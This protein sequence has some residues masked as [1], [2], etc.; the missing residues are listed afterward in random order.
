MLDEPETGEEGEALRALLGQDTA[1]D[2]LASGRDAGGERRGAFEEDGELHVRQHERPLPFQVLGLAAFEAGRVGDATCRK[3]YNRA[4]KKAEK[5]CREIEHQLHN[6]RMTLKRTPQSRTDKAISQ[7]KWLR[8][9]LNDL[10]LHF[11]KA[12]ARE[13]FER[14]EMITGI[15]RKR[16]IS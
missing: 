15:Q 16:G 11:D 10:L 7:M 13:Q 9:E 4:K 5:H 14:G 8:D 6:L 1:D 12:T 3:R 2:E